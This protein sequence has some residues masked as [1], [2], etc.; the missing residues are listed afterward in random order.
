MIIEGERG[1]DRIDLD[2]G[3]FIINIE[4]D[5]IIPERENYTK[6]AN[7]SLCEEFGNH[8][9]LIRNDKIVFL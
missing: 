5:F 8:I 9:F 4:K 3:K 2:I 7:S 1:L 6:R